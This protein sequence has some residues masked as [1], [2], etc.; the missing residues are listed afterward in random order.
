MFVTCRSLALVAPA[1][2]AT[3]G[4]MKKQDGTVLPTPVPMM[5]SP[6]P[7]LYCIFLAPEKARSL[8]TRFEGPGRSS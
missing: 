8:V 3:K 5:P 4:E 6:F 7:G 2:V 1:H